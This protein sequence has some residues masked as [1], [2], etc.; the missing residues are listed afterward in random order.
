MSRRYLALGCV[1]L[2]VLPFNV[3]A[4]EPI[5][6]SLSGRL[7]VDT[8]LQSYPDET[9]LSRDSALAWFDPRNARIDF[10]TK[11][12]DRY[13]LKISLE[14]VSTP[15]LTDVYGE[16]QWNDALGLRMGQYQVPYG[17]EDYGSSKYTPFLEKAAI[18]RALSSDRNSGVGLFGALLDNAVYYDFGLFSGAG[19][20]VPDNNASVNIAGR[21]AA[22]TLFMFEESVQLWLGFSFDVGSQKATSDSK[23]TVRPESRSD[24][25]LFRATFE[26]GREYSQ[27][28]IGFDITT[29]LGPTL[30]RF[31]YLY[32]NYSFDSSAAV[33]GGYFLASWIVTG[34]VPTLEFGVSE[35]QKVSDPVTEDGWGAIEILVRYSFFSAGDNF[36]QANGLYTGWEAVSFEDNTDS[37]SGL[38]FGVNWYLTEEVKVMPNWVSTFA[39]Q[40]RP[41]TNDSGE[42]ALVENAMLFRWQWLF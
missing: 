10:K 41:G 23:V 30:L 16:R 32:T 27:S 34:E 15:E 9:F 38:T 26:E 7:L 14:M 21:V 2:G 4:A 11:L 25:R 20:N 37:G 1:Y 35:K 18:V 36:F 40:K 12:Y 24:T 6:T 29:V 13:A 17:N 3:T 22:N 5:K 31:E 8:R 33:S 19:P 28:K 39:V 42:S